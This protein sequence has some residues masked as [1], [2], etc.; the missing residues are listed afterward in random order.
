MKA[1]SAG[2]ADATAVFARRREAENAQRPKRI[3]A[4]DAGRS[5]DVTAAIVRTQTRHDK[6]DIG[7]QWQRDRRRR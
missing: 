1:K 2:H 6:I 7:R 4:I 5:E 3:V